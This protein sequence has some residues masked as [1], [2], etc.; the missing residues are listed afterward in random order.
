MAAVF[1][2]NGDCNLR[3]FDR[4]KGDKECVVAHLLCYR[5]RIIL[6]ILFYCEDLCGAG[7]CCNPVILRANV[8]GSA[9]DP[10]HHLGHGKDD[11][12]PVFLVN[13]RELSRLGL[14]WHCH[15]GWCCAGD[16]FDHPGGSENPTSRQRCGGVGK[17]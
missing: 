3:R 16:L 14:Q 10:L 12:I 13:D 17:L 7:L 15:A 6:L 9:A 4:G 2:D 1:D 11:V 5:L 8:A